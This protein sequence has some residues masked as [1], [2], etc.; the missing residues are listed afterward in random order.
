MVDWTLLFFFVFALIA[1]GGALYMLNLYKVVHMAVALAFTFFGLAG[2][3]VLLEA[4]FIAFAQIMVYSGAITILMLYGIM[5]TRH[6]AEEAPLR[7]PVHTAL[8]FIGTGTLFAFLFYGIMTTPWPI[9]ATEPLA[10]NN[11]RE[12]GLALFNKYVIPF[13]LAAILLL[14][15]LVGAVVLAKRE[16]EE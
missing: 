3:Y 6:D 4:E 16:V 10:D 1:L 5:M 13:E 9:S 2:L 12:L 14:V 8:A 11:V 7:R 15:A